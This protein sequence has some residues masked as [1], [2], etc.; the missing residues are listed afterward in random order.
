MRMAALGGAMALPAGTALAQPTVWA[1]EAEQFEYRLG[2]GSD[3]LAW[4]TDFYIGT[5]ELKVRWLSE[6][7][8]ALEEDSFEELQNQLRLQTPVSDFWDVVAGVRVDTPEGPDRV[9]AVVGFHGLAPQWI[10][11]DADLYISGD[12][13]FEIDAEYEALLT[14]RLILTP[15]LELE[16]PL[17]DDQAIGSGAFAPKIEVGARLSY[18]VVD[19]LFSPYVGV[20]YE[21]AFGESAD[22]VRA[23]GEDAGSLYFVAGAKILF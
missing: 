2:E 10:E 19:R 4:D 11:V 15:S 14:N 22:L 20:H 21:R 12:P 9:Y 1:F 7:A 13:I 8:Y 3:Q 6:G 5:D 23:D 17:T 16:V 18:D